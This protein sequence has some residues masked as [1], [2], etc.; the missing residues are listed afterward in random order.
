MVNE[1]T[2]NDGSL[3]DCRTEALE[4]SLI[5]KLLFCKERLY[6]YNHSRPSETEVRERILN[7]VF[8]QVGNNVWIE[9]P[10]YANWGCHMHVGDDVYAN[11]GLTVV[12]DADIIIGD[13]VMIGPQVVIA[14]A[15]HPV[16]PALRAQALQYNLPVTVEADV[17]IG[18]GAILLPG[19]TIGHGSVIGAGSVVTKDIPADS[20]A[21]GNPCRVLRTVTEADRLFYRKG[22]ATPPC[23]LEE[24]DR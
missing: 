16:H 2:I 24:K 14:T 17:W 11:Y 19:V 9:P 13:R 15:G 23:F 10:F 1:K 12:D 20:V 5:E 22:V 4:P 3:Y 21:V 7:E 18:A 8:A 6:D